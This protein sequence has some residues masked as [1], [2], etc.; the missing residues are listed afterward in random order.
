MLEESRETPLS[1]VDKAIATIKFIL[2]RR[3][4]KVDEILKR[5]DIS[6]AQRVYIGEETDLIRNVE[7]LVK[8]S[9]SKVHEMLGKQ[10]PQAVDLEEA[11]LGVIML[12]KN[13]FPQ[14][15]E[16]LKP[17][18]FYMDI[19]AI[20]YQA[21]LTLFIYNQ[22]IDMRTVAN[23]LRKRGQLEL[24]G[25]AYHIAELTSKVSSAANVQFH[26]AVIIEH[27]IL[28]ELI[29]LGSYMHQEVWSDNADCFRII[30]DVEGQLSTMKPKLLKDE[31]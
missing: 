14:V 29:S 15:S 27:S 13:A 3:Q 1:K 26:A 21:C 23:E 11:V 28:R 5:V 6:E 31:V 18:H 12:E 8:A 4:R 17:K 30:D 19:H 20:I 24:V 9:T 25:G 10:L 22:P 7:V 2:K 16:L